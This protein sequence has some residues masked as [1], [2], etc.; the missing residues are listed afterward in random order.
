M[1]L[2]QISTE[3]LQALKTGDLSKV[4]S[5]GLVR[6]RYQQDLQKI[7]APKPVEKTGV[8]G[9]IGAGFSSVADRVSNGILQAMNSDPNVQRGLKVI[10]KQDKARDATIRQ[11]HPFAFGV[12]EALP[13]MAVPG[14]QATVAGRI[15]APAIG[16]ALLEGISYGTPEQRLTN[17]AKGAAIGAVGGGV[18]EVLGRLIKPMRGGSTVP[19]EA[20]DAAGRLEVPLS[21]GQR[22]GSRVL[23]KVEDT[24]YQTPL[25]GSVIQRNVDAQKTAINRAAA[26][27]A[28]MPGDLIDQKYLAGARAAAQTERGAL[29]SAARVSPV[30][31]DLLSAIS[32]AQRSLG[33]MQQGPKSL[34]NDAPADK[35]IKDFTDFVTTAQGPM[36]GATY[37]SWKTLLTNA[38]NAAYKADDSATGGIYKDLLGGLNKAA[39]KGNAGAWK[40]SDIKFST[41][42][43]LEQP[44]VVNEVTG[45]V[46][47]KSLAAAFN[48]KYG[49]A[50]KEGALPGE[51][52]DIASFAKGFPELKEGS[53]TAGR[54][55]MGGILG[56]AGLAAP[57]TTTGLVAGSLLGSKAVTSPVGVR[58][59]TEGFGSDAVQRVL[60]EQAQRAGTVGGVGALSGLGIAASR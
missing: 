11:D 41:L 19:S 33:S 24:L 36:D 18:G 43:I 4:S 52:Q 3:D 59:L 50:A 40:K 34:I 53:Q 28:G 45:N 13:L 31:I 8:L 51:L 42:D 10:D 48:R 17:A 30:D 20:L 14:G 15:A 1:D 44:N 26:R 9:A 46:N 56:G 29:E 6:L 25:A 23:N 35:I 54:A 32:K 27:S 21:A 5:E 57:L 22:T 2:S 60:L 7:E 49:A 39:Q 38:R 16:N 12:G 37:Q 55:F 47:P 58:Y